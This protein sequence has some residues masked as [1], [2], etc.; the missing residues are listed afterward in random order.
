MNNFT[1]WAIPAGRPPAFEA[2]AKEQ[3]ILSFCLFGNELRFLNGALRNARL[4]SDIYPGWTCRFYCDPSVPRSVI[5][6]LKGLGSQVVMR[7]TPEER[8]D[9][10]LWRVEVI[11]DPMIDRFLIRDCD[12]TINIRERV[13]VDEWIASEKWFHAMRDHSLQTELISGGMW[14]GISGVFPALSRLRESFRTG[15]PAGRLNE[16]EFLREMIWPTI[17]LNVLMHDSVYTGCLGSV[18]FPKVGSLPPNRFVGQPE[19]AVADKPKFPPI[20]EEP[21]SVGRFFLFGFHSTE[22]AFLRQLLNAHSDAHCHSDRHL[23][24]IWNESGNMVSKQRQVIGAERD[25][26][27]NFPKIR[28]EV[29]RTFLENF[30]G[31]YPDEG[32]TRVGVSDHQI[33]S[34]LVLHGEM[35]PE[36]KFLFVVRDPRQVAV[37]IWESRRESE[38]GFDR[39]GTGLNDISAEVGKEWV[40]KLDRIQAFN[41]AYPG[42]IELV[43]YEDLIADGSRVPALRRILKFLG[44]PVSESILGT[45]RYDLE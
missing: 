43:R 25:A 32:I 3:N 31:D 18:P 40:E 37:S 39:D 13:A 38:P 12:S 27:L 15:S 6:E 20:I 30:F 35:F 23:A 2:E 22:T 24:T 11:D 7:P 28:E 34:N 9:A 44:L 4:A 16:S 19:A 45:D 14:G 41:G 21:E 1:S 42:R 17:R 5:R 33:D 36:A 10:L 29:Y 26:G 8:E